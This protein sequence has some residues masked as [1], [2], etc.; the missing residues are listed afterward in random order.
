MISFFSS[1]PSGRKQPLQ[2]SASKSLCVTRTVQKG[3]DAGGVHD[4]LARASVLPF[5]LRRAAEL[6]A[7]AA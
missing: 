7:A 5:A 6:S 2:Q 3:Q 4:T 1:R